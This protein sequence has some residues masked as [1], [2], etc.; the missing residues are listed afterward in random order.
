MADTEKKSLQADVERARREFHRALKAWHAR[1]GSYFNRPPE[2]PQRLIDGC[3]VVQNRER[4]LD[5]LPRGATVAEVGTYEGRFARRILDV[6]DPKQLHVIDIDLSRIRRD[7]F[8]RDVDSGRLVFH[9]GDSSTVLSKLPPTS[10]DWIYIDGDHRYEGVRR[11]IEASVPLLKEHGLLV[12]ND[13]T[14]WSLKFMLP[15]GVATAV[16]ELCVR[17][18]WEMIYIALQSLG[19]YDVVVRKAVTESARN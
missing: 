9:E 4:L 10:F 12:F 15:C 14:S 6:A 13:Y 7:L 18:D 17:D 16:N 3:R 2:L 5:L 1:Y 8:Q 19:Y 11:D